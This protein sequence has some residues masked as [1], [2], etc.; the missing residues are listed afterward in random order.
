MKVSGQL[1]ALTTFF[2]RKKPTVP[3]EEEAGWNPEVFW[4]DNSV[5]KKSLACAGNQTTIL[6]FSIPYSGKNTG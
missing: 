1:Y 3:I 4:M 5:Q 6:L 2:S